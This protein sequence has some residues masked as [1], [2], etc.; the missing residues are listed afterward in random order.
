MTL[1]K[2]FCNPVG[3][4]EKK[5]ARLS[6]YPNPVTGILLLEGLW[7]EELTLSNMTGRSF[8]IAPKNGSVNI[9]HLP[10]GVYLL[11]DSENGFSEKI[12]LR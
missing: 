12:V 3:E 11:V 9:M 5:R 2:V 8:K 7:S 1:E 6:F 10:K 4:A